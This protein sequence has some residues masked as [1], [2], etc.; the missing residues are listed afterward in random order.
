MTI[1]LRPGSTPTDALSLANR[2]RKL[3]LAECL[4]GISVTESPVARLDSEVGA[5]GRSYAIKLQFHEPHKYP[6]VSKPCVCV[7]VACCG[8]QSLMC[9]QMG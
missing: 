3:K 6:K 2:M 8:Q 7:G 9:V 4:A 5:Y 1:P